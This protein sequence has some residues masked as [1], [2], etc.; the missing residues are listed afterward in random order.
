MENLEARAHGALRLRRSFLN[1]LQP[2]N[3]LLPDILSRIIRYIPCED[4]TDTQAT[5]SLTHVCRYWREF[6]IS[7]PWNWTLI[8]NEDKRLAALSLQRA[9]AAPLE[10]YLDVS[11]PG[12]GPKFFKLIDPYIQNIKTLHFS[13]F[14]KVK[15]LTGILRNFPRL[16]PNLQSL[17]LVRIKVDATYYTSRESH[18]IDPFE[19]LAPGLRYLELA[20][21]PLYPS[22]PRLRTLTELALNDHRFDLH[23]DTLLDFLEENRSLKNATLDIRCTEPSLRS[24]RHRAA[25]VNQLQHL[26]INASTGNTEEGKALIAKIALQRGAHLELVF[27]HYEW[28]KDLLT[29]IPTTQLSNLPSPIFMEHKCAPS[30]RNLRLLGPNGSFLFRDSYDQER[31]PVAFHL[32][33]LA[34]IREL[35]LIHSIPQYLSFPRDMFNLSFFPALETFAI[36][37][38][39]WLPRL[40]SDFLSNPSFPHSLKTLSFLNCN[41]SGDFMEEL[42]QFASDRKNVTTSAWLHRVVIVDSQENL[43]NAASIAELGKHVQTVDVRVGKELP[44]DL[45]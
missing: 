12:P 4:D 26:S 11:Q 44:T 33:P 9:K 37:C 8:S 28:L 5:I 35:R 43:P 16:S 38:G 1:L 25:I 21:V 34:H 39:L 24:P 41:L 17:A 27:D 36:A 13:G 18:S 19:S 40:L 30:G 15:T 31:P 3:R 45:A 2:V 20:D 6:I 23:L 22:F 14:Q 10:V 7:T 29:S 42:T 32:L